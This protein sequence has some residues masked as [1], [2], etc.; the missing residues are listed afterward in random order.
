MQFAGEDE[1]ATY[2]EREIAEALPNGWSSMRETRNPLVWHIAPGTLAETPPEDYRL[3]V[4]GDWQMFVLE[5]GNSDI[6]PFQLSHVL[7][8]AKVIDTDAVD[9]FPLSKALGEVIANCPP[10]R[11]GLT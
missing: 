6:G 2:V 5:Y 4:T 3:R 9:Y 10:N 7:L 1:V 11:W 8:N